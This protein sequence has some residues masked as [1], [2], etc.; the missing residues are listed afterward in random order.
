MRSKLVLATLVAVLSLVGLSACA[1]NEAPTTP[2]NSAD[3]SFAQDMIPHHRQATEMARLASDRSQND[4][5]LDLASQISA[6]QKPE[7]DTMTGWLKSW[8]KKVPSTDMNG[9]SGMSGMMSDDQMSSLTASTGKQFDTMF[10]TMMTAHH[11]GA[12]EMAAREE[13]NGRNTHA[14]KLAR[15]IQTDQAAEIRTMRS[16]LDS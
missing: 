7:I 4:E 10:L 2:F 16:L 1:D 15:K 12:I 6:A 9:M 8:D 14:V 11:Q 13:A 5:V 3:V